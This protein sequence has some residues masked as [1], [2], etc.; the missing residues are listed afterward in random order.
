MSK[1]IYVIIGKEAISMEYKQGDIIKG[2]VSGIEDYGIFVKLENNYS[3]LIHISEITDGFVNSINNFVTIGEKIYVRVLDVDTNNKQMKL[4]IKNINYKE[5]GKT[6]K[7]PESLRG[8]LPLQEEL[9]KW[10]AE[11]L[12]EIDE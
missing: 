8:F 6:Q 9:P 12:K 4:S 3:G 10:T 11:K 2:E 7:I 1:E 5:S